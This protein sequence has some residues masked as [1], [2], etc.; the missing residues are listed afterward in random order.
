MM[1]AWAVLVVRGQTVSG[2]MPLEPPTGAG[3]R[4]ISHWTGGKNNHLDTTMKA[5]FPPFGIDFFV[6]LRAHPTRRHSDGKLPG[7]F[8]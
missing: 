3:R 2:R 7:G 8:L 5:N 6:G 1:I 4:R